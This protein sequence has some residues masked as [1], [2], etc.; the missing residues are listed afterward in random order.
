MQCDCDDDFIRRIVGTHE[1]HIRTRN[2]Q[3]ST[4]AGARENGRVVATVAHA[5]SVQR[6]LD[7][8]TTVQPRPFLLLIWRSQ[9]VCGHVHT[10]THC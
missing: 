9:S 2:R 3:V 7:I 8:L 5:R 1:E 6:A 4:F 10:Y